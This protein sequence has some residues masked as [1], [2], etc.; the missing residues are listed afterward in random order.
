MTSVYPKV[1]SVAGRIGVGTNTMIFLR[2]LRSNLFLTL[3]LSA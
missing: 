1:Y 3:D 2:R